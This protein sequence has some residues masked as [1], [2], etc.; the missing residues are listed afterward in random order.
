MLA[1]KFFS[2]ATYLGTAPFYALAIIYF[3]LRELRYAIIMAAS[4]AFLECAC[5][6][7]KLAA[8]TKRPKPVR[9]EARTLYQKYDAASFP[10]IHSA[11]M[12]LLSV[13]ASHH[14]LVAAAGLSAAGAVVAYSRIY[15]K[16]HYLKDVLAGVLIGTLI[17]AAALAMRN[18]IYRLF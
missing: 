14:G 17:G 5:A 11:R 10:S 18:G 4:M 1:K 7:I 16:K 9:Q 12:A 3:A 15:L 8:P 6:L 2:A 13:L